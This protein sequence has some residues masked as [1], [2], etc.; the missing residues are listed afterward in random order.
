MISDELVQKVAQYTPDIRALTSLREIP[1]VLLVAPSG[2]GKNAIINGLL[3]KYPNDYKFLL[4]HTTRPPRPN[5]GIME[6]DGVNY[7]FIDF[8]QAEKLLNAKQYVE[9]NWYAGNIYGLT[10]NEILAAHK[11]GKIGVDEIEAQG[12]NDFAER[13][14]TARSIFV[15]APSFDKWLNRLKSRYGDKQAVYAEDLRKRMQTA[16]VEL[17]NALK[18][19]HFSFIINDNLDE[20]VAKVDRL[21]RFGELTE[22]QTHAR[23]IAMLLY[24][25]TLTYLKT[26]EVPKV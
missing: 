3:K 17:E 6:Q 26:L 1:I 9:V 8:D 19:K 10:V 24:Q 21:A 7:H 25:A 14:P 5:H 18:S 20:A 23:K 12:A 2:T 4:S 11:E 15:L 22:E 16:A 13:V